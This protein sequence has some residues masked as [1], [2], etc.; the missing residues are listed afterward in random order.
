[1]ELQNI[2]DTVGVAA[3]RLTRFVRDDWAC[4]GPKI[5]EH[6][7][8]QSFHQWGMAVDVYVLVGGIAIWQSSSVINVV[9]E[10]AKGEGIVAK[11]HRV[12]NY[13]F[14]WHHLQFSKFETPLHNLHLVG[15]WSDVE[16]A[17]AE[18]FDI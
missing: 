14:P 2:R 9:V 13:L 1:V 3:P 12:P 18:R 8:G 17:M 11:N 6:L 10:V 16:R 15:G 4:F 7:P 5:T